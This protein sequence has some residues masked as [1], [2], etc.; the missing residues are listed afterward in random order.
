[1]KSLRSIGKSII[2]TGT[3]VP[4]GT[5]VQWGLVKLILT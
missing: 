5:K 1:M 3:S 2:S 4:D